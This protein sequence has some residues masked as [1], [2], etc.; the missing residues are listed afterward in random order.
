MLA[1]LIKSVFAMP[2]GRFI[3]RG[4]NDETY[5]AFYD[6]SACSVQPES[7]SVKNKIDHEHPLDRQEGGIRLP[8]Q[9]ICSI[10]R[11]SEKVGED[12]VPLDVTL[13]NK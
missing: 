13:N 11:P 5:Q 10:I 7:S 6:C 2:S 3:N 9:T 12:P 8:G 1:V 4:D